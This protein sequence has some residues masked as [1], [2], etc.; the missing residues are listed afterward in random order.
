MK[1]RTRFAPSPTGLLHIGGLRT[2]LF[3]WAFAKQ[4]GGEFVLRV[5]DTDT[6]RSTPE[7]TRAILDG[8]SWAG[9]THD[10][11]PIFQ[12]DRTARYREVIDQLLQ[13]GHAY[14]CYTTPAELDALRETQRANNVKARYDGKWRPSGSKQ[15]PVPPHNSPVVRFK[16]PQSG[17]VKWVDLVKGPIEIQ[18]S[19]LDDLIIAR[20]DG[21]P[22]Y[23]LCVVVDD[24][25]MGITHVIRGD[26]HVNNTP[27]QIHILNALGA[28]IPE[29]AHLPMI[30]NE[31]GQKMSKRRDPVS[32]VD[33]ASIGILPEALL[34]YLARL[35]WSHGDSEYFTLEQFVEW[36][37]FKNVT[38]SPAR[39]DMNKLKWINQQHI[40]HAPVS[41]LAKC[42]PQHANVDR[43]IELIR[44]RCTTL[45]ELRE[46]VA[47]FVQRLTPTLS[48]LEK[49]YFPNQHLLSE[50]IS[51]TA[52]EW[53]A[54][55][56]DNAIREFCKT[57][58]IKIAQLA[59]PLRLAACGTTQTPSIGAVLELLG[60]HETIARVNTPF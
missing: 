33:Y 22:T 25:D 16:T 59:M 52:F 41:T 14:Y 48:D 37:D 26:D 35:G 11:G 15:L 24:W 51:N 44:P 30:L 7:S 9:L 49:H 2:A 28:P 5:E 6:Q 58:A 1:V 45:T 31:N 29:Y 54:D 42:I 13:T 43:I 38:E 32:V 12:S 39:F 46:G 57:H 40:K 17:S 18:N 60:K 20:S 34:N 8:M 50:F 23:N 53:R 56:I 21:T 19:E 47:P 4:H 27:R 10:Y 3:S 36:F 55:C